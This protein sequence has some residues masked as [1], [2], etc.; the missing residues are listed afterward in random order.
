MNDLKIGIL[1]AMEPEIN[2]IISKLEKPREIALGKFRF[3][4]GFYKEKEVV[5]TECSIGK[6]NS[7]IST[8]VMINH[9]NP[10]FIINTGIAGGLDS[11]LEILSIVIGDSLTYHDLD[12]DILTNYFPFTTH[13]EADKRAVKLTEEIA[14]E[15]EIHTLTGTIVTGDLFVEDSLKKEQLRK[16][17]NALC[18]EME[19][20]A[21]A[22]TSFANDIP[23]IIIRAISDMADDGGYMTYEEFKEK[24][25]DE[26]ATIVLKLIERM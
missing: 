14:K 22:H 7:A 11:R 17:Y 5:V 1:G 6:V 24:A 10:D 26:S 18:V 25:S 4:T 9:F 3:V 15:E 2:L 12:Y 20:A 21:I 13:F 23:F 16:D 19:G 8:Q